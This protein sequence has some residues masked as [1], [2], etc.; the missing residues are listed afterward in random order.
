MSC[1]HWRRRMQRSE[2]DPRRLM[3]Y[4]RMGACA[5]RVYLYCIPRVIFIEQCML[6]HPHNNL[7][8]SDT[9]STRQAS[10]TRAQA[11]SALRR[12]SN[13]SATRLNTSSI[14]RRFAS[15]FMSRRVPGGTSSAND[16]AY[17]RYAACSGIGC[18]R[19]SGAP[20]WK[21]RVIGCGC[22]RTSGVPQSR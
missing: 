3:C 15:V 13:S 21:V 11:S 18:A 16:G 6:R 10:A 19:E 4:I 2:H 5:E 20:S 7:M 9:S 8:S 17:A 12:F 1:R 14:S 22:K